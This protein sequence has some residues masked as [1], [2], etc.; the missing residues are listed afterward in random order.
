MGFRREFYKDAWRV[1]HRFFLDSMQNAMKFNQGII[2][3]IKGLVKDLVKI[4]Q[5]SPSRFNRDSTS[6]A[7]LIHVDYMKI[8]LR[9]LGGFQRNSIRIPC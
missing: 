6:N 4:L 1:L 7:I 9:I 5:G 2:R 3:I 8:T